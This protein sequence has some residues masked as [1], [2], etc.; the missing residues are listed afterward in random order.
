MSSNESE[1]RAASDAFYAALSRMAGGDASGISGAWHHGP[2]VT[3]MHP[4]GG[5][6]VGWDAVRGSFEQFAELATEGQVGIADSHVQV[7]GDA[8][9]ETGQERGHVRLGG[10]S[11]TI[12]HRVTNV[13]RRG[14]DGWTLV[15]HHADPSSAM[16][17][18]LAR[19]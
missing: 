7:V 16:M 4:I 6:Q 17:E 1:V 18:F 8:A 11:M 12:D 10:E 2:E 9:I 13:Y 15:H 5:M 14:P 3:A 19:Q